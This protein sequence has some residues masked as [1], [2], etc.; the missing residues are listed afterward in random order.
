MKHVKQNSRL[1]VSSSKKLSEI[2]S[3][4]QFCLKKYWILSEK[5]LFLSDKNSEYFLI[6]SKKVWIFL[7]FVWK[8]PEFCECQYIIEVFNFQDELKMLR[9]KTQ[10][11]DNNVQKNSGIICKFGCKK[12]SE[13]I[14]IFSE[15]FIPNS[16]FFF[17]KRRLFW[18]VINLLHV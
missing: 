18:K 16:D 3:S 1:Q 11:A 4:S 5:K 17:Y 2:F 8:N 14:K 15:I 7:N 12:N 13:W 6:S 9:K 10:N